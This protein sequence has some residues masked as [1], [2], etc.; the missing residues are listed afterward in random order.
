MGYN[1]IIIFG[2][3]LELYQYEKQYYNDFK[4]GSRGNVKGESFV[5]YN[6]TGGSDTLAKEQL[7][8]RRDNAQR[9]LLA[10]RRIILSNLTGSEGPILLTLTFREEIYE[11]KDGYRAFSLFIQSL[12]Y[13]YGKAFKYACVPE[14]QRRGVVHFHAL[15]WGLPTE[16]FYSE[17]RTRTVAELWGHGFIDMIMTDGREN[18]AYY[19]AKYMLK[20]HLDIRL[21]NQKAYVCS[22]NIARPVV[23]SGVPVWPILDD[24][25][26]VDNSL[27]EQREFDTIWLGRCIYQRYILSK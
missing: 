19:L 8:R 5:Q 3:N 23:Y 6:A 7:G 4:G 26:A 11:L 22:R 25:G 15:F 2:N 17:R 24:Y 16:L 10:F 18:L 12:R 20:A 14:F 1:K 27:A 9:V 13:K 21:R